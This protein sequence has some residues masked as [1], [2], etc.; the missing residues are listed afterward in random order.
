M[1]NLDMTTDERPSA[2]SHSA[3]QRKRTGV[4]FPGDGLGETE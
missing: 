4:P 1:I 3:G 2:C